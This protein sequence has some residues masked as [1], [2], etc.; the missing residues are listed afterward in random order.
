MTKAVCKY[1]DAP[2]LEQ[3]GQPQGGTE[4]NQ[5]ASDESLPNTAASALPLTTLDEQ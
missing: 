1:L 2:T 3:P 4:R 5:Q